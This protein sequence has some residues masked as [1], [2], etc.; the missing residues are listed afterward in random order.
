MHKLSFSFGEI[1]IFIDGLMED[2]R[3]LVGRKGDEKSFVI[4]SER[5]GDTL[6]IQNRDKIIEELING[7]I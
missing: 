7:E 1:P 2:D 4:V 5:V 3:V 6:T